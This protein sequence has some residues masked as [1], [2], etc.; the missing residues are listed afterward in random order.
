MIFP[1]ILFSVLFAIIFAVLLDYGLRRRGPGP[2]GGVL[3][4]FLIIFMFTLGFG[5]W[6]VIAL[7]SIYG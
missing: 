5:A 3:F 4:I 6:G 2:A 1:T 7:M